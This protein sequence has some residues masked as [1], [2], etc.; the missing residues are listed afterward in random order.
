MM[1][2]AWIKPELEI[3]NIQMTMGGPGLRTPDAVQTD[4]DAPDHDDEV[5]HHS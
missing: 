4:P 1:K 3:L 2:K 5:L